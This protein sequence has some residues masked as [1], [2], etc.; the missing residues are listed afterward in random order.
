MKVL[1]VP[2]SF[3]STLTSVRAAEIISDVFESDGFK[4]NSIPVGDGGEGTID[5]ILYS[6]GGQ[7]KYVEVLDPLGRKIKTYYGLKNKT[8]FIEIS[9]SSGLMLLEED[10]YDPSRTTTIGF[11]QLIKDAMNNGPEK[12]Y[13]GLGGTATNDAG[14]GML[15]A[16]GVK[17][18]DKKGVEIQGYLCGSM[19]E[20]IYHVDIKSLNGNFKNTE[21][22]VM[23]DVRNPLTGLSGATNVFAPQKGAYPV[24]VGKLEK[25]MLHFASVIKKELNFDLNFP[26]AGAAGGAGAVLKVF[27]NAK[28]NPGIECVIDLL[29]IEKI[30]TETD[31]VIVG[32]GSL[33]YQTAFGKAPAGIAKIAKKYNKKVIAISGKLGKNAESLYEQGIDLIFSYY[34]DVN[35]NL[36]YIKKHSEKMLKET[37]SLAK[38][39]I[40][41]NPNL[42]NRKF[43]CYETENLYNT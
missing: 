23:S 19:L 38:D 7:K 9:K 20:E 13:L 27:L 32:E 6:L 10:E 2:D 40:I 26:G 42:I 28:M 33:D 11:G 34:G 39:I 14:I 18:Y 21:I 35:V 12:I 15:S 1:I 25:G 43:I 3:K 8:A 17:F 41:T 36:E 30:I 31:L 29:G 4:T 16:L 22:I 24:M 5:A 37:A